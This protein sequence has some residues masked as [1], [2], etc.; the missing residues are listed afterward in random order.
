MK[1]RYLN[2]SV[3]FL[4]LCVGIRLHFC[5]GFPL[6]QFSVGTLCFRSVLYFY[7]KAVV[8]LPLAPY[9]VFER[10]YIVHGTAFVALHI[11]PSLYFFL[12]LRRRTVLKT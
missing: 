4:L 8:T 12:A 11:V 7:S 3:F 2:P 9:C 5:V 1:P 6:C 10:I